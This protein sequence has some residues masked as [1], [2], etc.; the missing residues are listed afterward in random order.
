MEQ[1][2]QPGHVIDGHVADIAKGGMCAWRLPADAGC[3]SIGRSLVQIALTTMGLGRDIVD[4][5]SLVA[6]ELATNALHHGLRA[7]PSAPI[8]PPEL[9]VWARTRPVRQLVVSVFDSCRSSWPD[10]T[11]HGLLDEHGRGIGIVGAVAD[12][13]GAHLSR[14]RLCT[15][16][17]PGKAV[18]AV[19]ALPGPWP[20]ART[21]APPM[22]AARHL[23]STL[24]SCGIEDV[25]YRHGRSVSLLSIRLRKEETREKVR[26]EVNVW[27]EP[28]HL[29]F[30]DSSGSRVRRPIVDLHDVAESLVRRY[31]ETR[32]RG[33]AARPG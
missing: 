7:V 11:P 8:V 16:G 5:A 32:G 6:S 14:S 23:A 26:D 12:G 31:E 33:I 2:V 18:W 13:W 29:S 25:T 1:K 10:T 24:I 20:D 28:G 4:D 19:F 3:A 30:T 22:L 9:W 15:G 21:T 17:V 27:V